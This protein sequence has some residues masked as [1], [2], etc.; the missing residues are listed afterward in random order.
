MIMGL[1]QMARRYRVPSS[2]FVGLT[3]AKV[4]DAQSGLETGMSTLATLLAGA[5]LM[6][7][8][9]VLDGLMVF[10]LAKAVIDHEIALM[11]KRVARGVD[12]SAEDLA[13]DAIAEAGPGG[14]FIDKR[15]TL[16]RIRRTALLPEIADRQTRER[17]QAGG[18]LDSGARALR[19]ARHILSR[20]NPAVFSPDLDA[21]IRARFANLVSGDARGGAAG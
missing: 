21:R 2:G 3:N 9:G 17:W 20:D 12:F 6:T 11:L 19:R 18:A 5:D 16:A 15:H 8:G 4:N 14:S 1:V 13:L 10:D 7:M